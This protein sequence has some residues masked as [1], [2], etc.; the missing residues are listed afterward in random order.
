MKWWI[1]Q[2]IQ[3]KLDHFKS[4]QLWHDVSVRSVRSSRIVSNHINYDIMCQSGQLSQILSC[5]IISIMK[6]CVN[7]VRSGYYPSHWNFAPICQQSGC[8][9]WYWSQWRNFYHNLTVLW[10]FIWGDLATVIITTIFQHTVCFNFNIANLIY[11][12]LI[13]SCVITY[14][15]MWRCCITLIRNTGFCLL[16]AYI[17]RNYFSCHNIISRQKLCG[18]QSRCQILDIS[19]QCSGDNVDILS[20]GC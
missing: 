18:I 3:V 9:G 15:T 19:I 7:R 8:L 4:Y 12:K 2:A 10:I 14:H 11:I 16:L 17:N 6:L 20:C 5:Q 1:R 13:H